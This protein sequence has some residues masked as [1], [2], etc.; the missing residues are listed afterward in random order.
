MVSFFKENLIGSDRTLASEKT[1]MLVAG[2]ARGPP[3]PRGAP[4]GY[5][6]LQFPG[7]AHFLV[8]EKWLSG[9][10]LHCYIQRQITHP[11]VPLRSQRV[12]M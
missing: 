5:G 3:G 11:M 12:G 8:P 1:A 9:N 10:H 2:L 4:R 6:A 7:R